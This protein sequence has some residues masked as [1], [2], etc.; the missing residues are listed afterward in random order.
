[1]TKTERD[2]VVQDP[3]THGSAWLYFDPLAL[4]RGDAPA[5]P[6]AFGSE[7]EISFTFS[8][9]PWNFAFEGV[10][11]IITND[12]TNPSPVDRAICEFQLTNLTNRKMTNLVSTTALTRIFA[13]NMAVPFNSANWDEDFQSVN[14]CC[15]R[16]V[17]IGVTSQIPS[18]SSY[19]LSGRS[20]FSPFTN[21]SSTTQTLQFL[22]WGSRT[23]LDQRYIAYPFYNKRQVPNNSGIYTNPNT[24]Y[25]TSTPY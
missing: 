19:S 13:S 6:G 8:R 4:T 20:V 15:P 21:A 1:M 16:N 10:S 11:A 9:R 23:P 2:I 7:S 14:F 17:N 12:T 25:P 22:A 18:Q 5:T 3:R 24:G